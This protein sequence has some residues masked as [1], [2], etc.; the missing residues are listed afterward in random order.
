MLVL[1]HLAFAILNI[2]LF[3]SITL[4][5]AGPEKQLLFLLTM[6]GPICFTH[7]SFIYFC[8]LLA[9]NSTRLGCSLPVDHQVCIVNVMPIISVFTI[10]REVDF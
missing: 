8:F 2:A 3:S 6:F 5:L 4:D 10:K 1:V 9:V 7:G